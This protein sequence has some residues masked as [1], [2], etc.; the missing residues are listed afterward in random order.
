MNLC[1]LNLLWLDLNPEESW[2]S[3]QSSIFSSLQKS[4]K[5]QYKLGKL[6][7]KKVFFKLNDSATLEVRR[8]LL[9]L[10]SVAGESIIW[11]WIQ[12]IQ[13]INKFEDAASTTPAYNQHWDALQIFS[14]GFSLPNKSCCFYLWEHLFHHPAIM[15]ALLLICFSLL[16]ALWVGQ[17]IC[18][19]H[20]YCFLR[21]HF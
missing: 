11:V 4:S 17:K 8:I 19:Y 9:V 20:C 5:G 6:L 7:S 3:L 1:P 13:H 16:C 12:N 2:W 10:T 14:L 21:F 18:W 15:P